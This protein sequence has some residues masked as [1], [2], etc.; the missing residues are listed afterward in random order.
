MMDIIAKYGSSPVDRAKMEAVDEDGKKLEV[1]L[2]DPDPVCYVVKT[3]SEAQFGDYRFFRIYSGSVK[4]ER[5]L[6]YKPAGRPKRSARF[7]Y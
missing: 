5:T 7:I 6:Q 3:M 4:F 2:T 1:S